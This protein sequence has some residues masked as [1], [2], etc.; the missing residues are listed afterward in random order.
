[1]T[2]I[3]LVDLAAAHREV[4]DEVAEGFAEVLAATAFVGGPQVA[5]F[6]EAFAAFCGVPHCA[7]VGNGTDALEL[8]LRALGVGPGDEVVVPA[9]TYIASAEAVVRAGAT[10]VLADVDPAT[11][12]L[13]PA[14]AAQRIGP[15]TRALLPVHLFGQVAP[16]AALAELAAGAGLVIV[17]DAA[18][19]QGARQDGRSAGGFGAAAGTSFYPGKNL[20]AYGDAGAVLTADAEVAARVRALRNHGGERRYEHRLVGTNSRLDTLQAVVLL[21]K[22]ARLEAG[23]AARR[24]AAERYDKLLGGLA[25]LTLPA[26]LAGNDHVWHLYVVRVPR[27]DEVLRALG[28]AGIGAGVHYP[29]PVHRTEAFAGL[30]YGPGDFPVAEQAAGEIL[31]LPLYPQITGEQQERVAEAL[32]AALR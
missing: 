20:G 26:T 4:A 23:N 16:M 28:A 15:R 17:E 10:P 31:S 3:P 22:L 27:R 5:A 29:A 8:A 1:M 19:A 2:T 13:D 25:G 6:E 9:N 14:S 18:Q 7:G 30:G 12:L 32:E 11:L 24:D 21:A